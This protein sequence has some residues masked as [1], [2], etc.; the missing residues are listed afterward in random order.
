MT[1]QRSAKTPPLA[2]VMFGATGDLTA[3]KLLPALASLVGNGSLAEG[4][5]L[6]GVARSKPSPVPSPPG[7]SS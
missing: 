6:V 1:V 7:E 3:R 4:L 5:V 2:L